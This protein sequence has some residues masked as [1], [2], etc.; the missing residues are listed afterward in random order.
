MG[1]T[2]A[3][4]T[5]T[6]TAWARSSRK[7]TER[8]RRW[9]PSHPATGVALSPRSPPACWAGAVDG[10]AALTPCSRVSSP[11]GETRGA[12]SPT[13]PSTGWLS[14]ISA[15]N[16]NQRTRS[17]SRGDFDA[18]DRAETRSVARSYNETIIRPV[19]RWGSSQ[20][21]VESTINNWN[22]RRLQSAAGT[23]YRSNGSTRT[24]SQV[25]RSLP[26]ENE[27]VA[28]FKN[29]FTRIFTAGR[30]ERWKRWWFLI[31]CVATAATLSSA[32]K[33]KMF[34]F[35]IEAIIKH[36]LTSILFPG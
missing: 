3:A 28:S 2:T 30:E 22:I 1:T 27:S 20:N 19:T 6:M 10:R 35:I 14:K 15:C 16:P 4:T 34:H 5:V 23:S 9:R 31:C 26:P 11:M 7:G 29:H 24:G 21:K 12:D 13:R 8:S 36:F 18:L 25:E 33:I 17:E 32:C